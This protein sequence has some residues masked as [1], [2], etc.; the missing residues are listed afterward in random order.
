[1][2]GDYSG[3]TNIV[4]INTDA[5]Y[6]PQFNVGAYAFWIVCRGIRVVQAGPLKTCID[7]HDAEVMAIANA[8][9]ALLKSEFQ[10]IKFI[11]INTDC[12]HAIEAIRDGN[13]SRYKNSAKAIKKCQNIIKDLKKKYNPGP[14]KFR[15]K[16][17]ISWRYV[18][19]HT[20]TETARLWVNDWLDKAAKKAL[21]EQ[22]NKKPGT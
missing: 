16:P 9:Y 20:S 14:A 18:K 22:I 19:A 10:G 13:K 1:M 4:T 2:I 17:F 11:V 21:W 12:T 6:H 7:S 5:S 3:T 8:L 15:K